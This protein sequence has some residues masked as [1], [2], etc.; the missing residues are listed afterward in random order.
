M[1]PY[2]DVEHK[3]SKAHARVWVAKYAKLLRLAHA[4]IARNLA[5]TPT[6]LYVR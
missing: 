1:S 5:G 3:I 2:V 4:C 6:M